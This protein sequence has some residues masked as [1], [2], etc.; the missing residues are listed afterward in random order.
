MVTAITVQVVH[1]GGLVQLDECRVFEL[2]PR[3]RIGAG[4]HGRLAQPSHRLVDDILQ[5]FHAVS[6][7]QHQHQGEGQA[8]APCEGFGIL[9]MAG[10]EGIRF[11]PFL[12]N[13]NSTF[14]LAMF[15][16]DSNRPI[17]TKIA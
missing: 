7:D 9:A 10:F 2:V 4:G 11:N 6:H 12:G 13:F 16:C 3:L 1:H 5:R 17:I 8:A 15:N 14:F